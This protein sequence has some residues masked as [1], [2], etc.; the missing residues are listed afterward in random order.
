VTQSSDSFIDE[1]S[2]ELRRDRLFALMRRWGWVAVLAVV[3][4]V[5]GAAW[6]EWRKASQNARAEAFGDALRAA[7]GDAD[8][9]A[10]IPARGA[11]QRA[12]VAMARAGALIGQDDTDAAVATLAAMAD[13]PE[14]E[15]LYR[16]LARLKAM[17]LDPAWPGPEA[18]AAVM[19]ELS[20][21]GAPFRPLAMEL[22]AL[23][24]LAAGDREA[25]RVA[26]DRLAEEPELPRNL[27]VRVAQMRAVLGP[28]G[29]R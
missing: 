2:D 5:G 12:V 27:A 22:A 6:N 4:I 9:L 16:D 1:V 23:E 11:E 14:I 7:T 15:P 18:R 21:P 28:G 10:A 17:S 26:F 20:A 8:R 19:A 13:D 25:A 29:E 24:L 3:L